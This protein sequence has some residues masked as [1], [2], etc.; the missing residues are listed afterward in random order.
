MVAKNFQPYVDIMQPPSEVTGSFILCEVKLPTTTVK[1]TVDCGLYQE[2]EYE[3]ENDNF[4]VS[5]EEVDFVVLTHNHVDHNGRLPFFVRHGFS[6]N[7]YTTRVTKSILGRSLDDNVRVLKDIR[8]Y[9]DTNIYYDSIDVQKTLDLV[10]GCDYNQP[11]DAHKYVRLHFIMNG[12]LFGAASV[13]A[14]IH[15]PGTDNIYILFSGDYNNKN[16]FFYVSPPRKWIT[17][18]PLTVII[19][20]T[21]G[22][23]D[24]R[25]VKRVFMGNVTS[26]I[27][28]GKTIVLPV[29]SLGRAQEILYVLKRMQMDELLDVN[30]P[31][32]YDGK[33][34]FSYTDAIM[35]MQEIGSL[36]FFEDKVDF[37]PEN[38]TRIRDPIARGRVINDQKSKIIVTT[39]GNGSYGSAQAYI[40]ELIQR[41]NVLIHFTGFCTEDSL[42]YELKRTPKH[43]TVWVSGSKVL[44]LADVEYTSEFSAHAKANELIGFLKKFKNLKLVLVNHGVMEVKDTF[45]GRVVKEVNCNDVGILG[46]DYFYRVNSYGLDKAMSTKFK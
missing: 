1:F 43:E 24:S 11:I 30:I 25:D 22:A 2:K 21:Y 27:A 33:L 39:S 3:R 12:H 41:K 40:K 26:A 36:H 9:R 8:K 37:M 34:S 14:E 17:Q 4:R 10:V 6:G 13:L 31:I 28:Q 7:I 38:L 19:E 45:A 18:L 35:R 32:Y 5:P 20:S 23:M 15:Y 42:G 29:F 16:M 44:K 46:K